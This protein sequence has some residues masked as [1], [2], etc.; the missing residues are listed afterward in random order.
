MIEVFNVPKVWEQL[1]HYAEDS[2]NALVSFLF[3]LECQ[4]VFNHALNVSSVL[5]NDEVRSVAVI[6]LKIQLIVDGLLHDKGGNLKM[7]ARK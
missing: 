1:S 5:R 3:V 6:R 4:S 2:S 7:T